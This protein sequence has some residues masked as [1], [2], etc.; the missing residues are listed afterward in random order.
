LAQPL[1]LIDLKSFK[2]QISNLFFIAAFFAVI[3]PTVHSFSHIFDW[4]QNEICIHKS[5]NKIN[6]VHKH[7]NN[8]HCANCH[9]SYLSFYKTGAVSFFLK[10]IFCY[11]KIKFAFDE[12][13]SQNYIGFERTT[14]GP[15]FIKVI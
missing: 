7:K 11:K 5:H 6:F 4:K 15:P 10:K 14:R 1:F 2:I 9:F 8:N 13:I 12:N 3:L